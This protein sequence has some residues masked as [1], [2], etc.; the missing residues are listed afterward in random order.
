MN[1]TI[2]DINATRKNIAVTLTGDDIAKEEKAV[3]QQF[4]K[5]ARIPGFR[6]GKAPEVQIR[7]RYAREIRDELKTRLGRAIYDHVLKDESLDVYTFVEFP[8]LEEVTPG[9]EATVDLVVD[10]NPSFDLPDYKGI[11]TQV[12]PADVTDAEI[13]A[14]IDN[15]RR[16]RADF[17]KVERPAAAGDYVRLSYAGKVDGEDVA[18]TLGDNPRL[19]AWGT[20]TDGWEEAGSEEAKQFGVPAI[21]DAI[22]GMGAD[23]RKE[24]EQQIADDFAVE[25]L[26]GRTVVYTIEVHEVRERILPEIDDEFLKSVRAESVEDLKAQV[27][28]NI[29][30][31]KK[32]E[33]EAAQREQILDH[34]FR[35][36][37]FPL[38]ESAVENETQNAMVRIMSRNMSEGV[39][40]SV[41]EEHKEQLHHS[42]SQA[43]QRDVKLQIIL[44][45]IAK[46]EEVKVEQEDLSRAVYGIAM[47]QRRQ[48]EEVAKELRKNQRELVQLQR[49]I[50]FSKTLDRIRS[51]AVTTPTAVAPESENA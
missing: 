49:Q 48:P 3:L 50:L 33:A 5:V 23:D 47:Q 14:A 12:P 26:R 42:A 2:T 15:M 4:A 37:D 40:E 38:P 44:G 32:Q 46:A 24:V 10:V 11:Q 8:D 16:S 29:E 18:E 27:A 22:V 41:F 20:V 19:R 7:R 31:R 43:A 35:A 28:D 17:I 39:P 25:S 45:R 21:I 6:P 13:E 36:V 51:M 34:L 1:L 9:S 30:S